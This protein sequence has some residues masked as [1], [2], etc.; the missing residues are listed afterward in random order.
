MAKEYFIIFDKGENWEI[1]DTMIV[2]DG[3]NCSNDGVWD[4]SDN[5]KLFEFV[6]ARLETFKIEF[7]KDI[8]GKLIQEDLILKQIDSLDVVKAKKIKEGK[9]L[10]SSRINVPE[11]FSFVEF[12]MLNNYL[13]NKGY[14]ITDENK[15]EKYLEIVESEDE[16]LIKKLEEYLEIK[17]EID[18][19]MF[20]QKIHKS[21]ETNITK[22]ITKKE[23]MSI[24]KE[25]VQT[26]E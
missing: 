7:P 15:Y 8:D 24:W 25:Y 11:L 12:I 4:I 2:P 9:E 16:E 21:F 17:E 22:A 14:I 20:W 5:K 10:I 3:Y 13:L 23:I 19:S 26:F 6:K 1:T 18:I